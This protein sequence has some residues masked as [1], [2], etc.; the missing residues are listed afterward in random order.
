MN[1][2]A[3]THNEKGIA[4]VGVAG[5]F[6]GA[7]TVKDFWRNLTDGVEGIQ[8]ASTEELTAAG[9]DPGLMAHPDYVPAAGRVHEPDYFDASFFG[10]SAREAEIIDPQQRVFLECAWDALEDAGCDASSYPGAIGVFA[11]AGMNTYGVINLFSNPDVIESAGGYQVM[12]GNDKDFLCSRVAYKLNLRGPAVGVQTACSTSLVAVQMAFESLL[13]RECD[14]ALAGGVSIP[15]PQYPGYLYV[16]GMILSRDGH[17]RAFDAAASGTV[18]GGGAGIAVLKRLDDAIADRDHI[19]AVIRGAAVNN[20]GSAKVGYSAPSVEGQ[21]SV[22]RKAMQMAGFAPESVGYIEAHGTGTEVGDPIEF[23]ALSK[24]FESAAAKPESCRLGSVKTNIGHL[25][26]AAGIAG[27][28]KT[29]LAVEHRAIPATL[30]FVKTNPLI[31]FKKTP[32]VVNSSLTAYDKPGP[33]RAGVSSFGIGGTNAHVSLEEA[34]L[35]P[36][37]P[38]NASQLIVLS[39]KTSSA[40][41]ARSSQLLG[42]LEENPT[43]NLADIAFTLQKGRQAFQHRRVLVGRDV[44]ALKAALE[45]PRSQSPR[46]QSLRTDKVPAE[47]QKTAFLFPGQGS[48]Y[49]NM[50]LD[51]YRTT[52]VF[53]D[54]VDRCCE[55][56]KPHLD[57]DL[58]GLLFPQPDQ[59]KEA[60]ARLNQTAI[61]QPALFVI[62]YSMAKLFMECG[63]QPVAML[64]HSVGEYVAACLAGVFS[65]EDA[66]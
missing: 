1:E 27:L 17:C 46:S 60:E 16:P 7:R 62:E 4:I 3:A 26:T 65:L 18:P 35:T 63:I 12:V 52:A 42:F 59:E 23:A 15:I 28:I 43:A 10:F 20:D 29:A 22:I 40:L 66:I 61:T 6:P 37:D 55:L 32:F 2:S 49:V 38:L 50:S 39:A 48:Q 5:R 13:R 19:Y 14:M 21:S 9:V 31:D 24:V 11:G 64:G 33:F 45:A 57:L 8:F 36:S 56:L 25:D 47:A 44:A 54:S 53:R 51:L 58:R 30:H 41:E 34:P